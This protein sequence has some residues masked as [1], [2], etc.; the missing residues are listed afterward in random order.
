MAS[1]TKGRI[2]YKK[3]I[4]KLKKK[5]YVKKYVSKMPFKIDTH[6]KIQKAI[7][8]IHHSAEIRNPNSYP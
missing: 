6:K 7:I 8:K 5:K 1:M 3:Y 4:Q 2:P